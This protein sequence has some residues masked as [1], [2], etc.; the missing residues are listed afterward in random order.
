M[1]LSE[2]IVF[3]QQNTKKK[4]SNKPQTIPN[5][6]LT[7]EIEAIYQ[8]YMID[9]IAAIP[10]TITD[11]AYGLGVSTS[12]FKMNFKARYGLS[13]YETY[14]NHKMIYAKDLLREGF[15]CNVVALK[16][17]Y[18]NGTKFNIMF[19]KH[20]NTTPKKYQQEQLAISRDIYLKTRQEIEQ[21]R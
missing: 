12:T 5:M 10:P 2:S 7:K 3:R 16:I 20:F 4:I 6:I 17:G 11:I 15:T 8:K 13:F 1:R 18:T 14:V 9:E 21:S 19:Q